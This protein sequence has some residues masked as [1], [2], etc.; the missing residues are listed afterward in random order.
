M[1][2]VLL[3]IGKT[4]APYLVDAIGEYAKRLQFYTPF[5]VVEDCTNSG[6]N[7]S[8]LQGDERSGGLGIPNPQIT[9]S[10]NP[11]K[12]TWHAASLLFT[13]NFTNFIHFHTFS[14]S[15]HG[16]ETHVEAFDGVS[17]CANGD[18][19]DAAFGVVAQG[20]EGDAAR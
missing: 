20:V 19:I 10:A 6:A 14:R 13:F 16:L 7:L 11:Q 17:K 12:R 15:L 4:T 2:I 1:K 9:K 8:P 3:W 5:E 18:K